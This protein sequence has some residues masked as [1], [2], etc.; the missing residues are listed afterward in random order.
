M[1]EGVL[2]AQPEGRR[3]L[4]GPGQWVARSEEWAASFRDST[5]SRVWIALIYTALSALIVIPVVF[6]PG[7]A[8]SRIDE[9]TH[10]DYAWQVAHFH[11]PEAGS[12]IAPEILDLWA[13]AGQQGYDLPPCGSHAPAAAFPFDGT[14]YNFGH[15]PLYYAAVGLP[16]RLASAAI[17]GLNFVQ[18]ARLTGVLWLAGGMFMMF[19]ALRRWKIDPAAAIIAPLLL[20][21]FPRILHASTTVNPDAA[22]ALTGAAAVWLAA[23]VFSEGYRDWRLPALLAGTAGMLKT[24]GAVPFIAIGV[25]ILV[26]LVR[27]RRTHPPAW[28]DLAIPAGI[29]GAILVPY[30][31]WQAYQSG[32]GDPNWE[33][34]LVGLNTRDVQGLPGSEWLETAFGGINLASDYYLQRPLDVALM[35]SWTRLLNVLVIGA[36]FAVIVACAKEPARRSLGWMMVTGVVLYPTIVQVQA[37]FNTTVPQYFPNV[38]GRYGLAL[39]PGAVAC[40]AIAAWKAGYRRFVYLLTAIGLAVLVIVIANGFGQA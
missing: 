15:P 19:V 31:A 33:N 22:A 24:I 8:W 9:P 17:P 2:V 27:D 32:R 14:N 30:L 23:L 12:E 36:V 16:A 29:A 25:L 1:D 28:S 20:P 38:T 5:R 40:I 21:A 7:T 13:C 35:V 37:F 11:L 3:K 39:I 6:G 26:R 4:V 10:A 34:P 18:A